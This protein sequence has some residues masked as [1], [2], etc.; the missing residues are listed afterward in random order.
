MNLRPLAA[1][2]LTIA[3]MAAWPA[4][5]AYSWGKL[6]VV[7]YDPTPRPTPPPVQPVTPPYVPP[8]A[9]PYAPPYVPIPGRGN[10]YGVALQTYYDSATYLVDALP[11][12][13]ASNLIGAGQPA[14]VIYRSWNCSPEGRP[15]ASILSADP[16]R[17]GEAL[18]QEVDIDFSGRLPCQQL[19]SAGLVTGWAA[20]G[21]FQL[22][23][24][25]R[26]Y[27]LTVIDQH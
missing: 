18:W 1:L 21:L 6:P 22:Q 4:L 10:Q 17:A 12:W 20:Q 7:V 27:R 8:Y 23:P 24:T 5:P 25:T 14:N 13:G 15:F 2:P 3:L 19:S 26:V 16:T 11:V 9:P